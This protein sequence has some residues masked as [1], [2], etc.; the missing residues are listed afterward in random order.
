MLLVPAVVLFGFGTLLVMRSRRVSYL[1]MVIIGMFGFALG[2]TDVAHFLASFLD[3][4]FP[5]SPGAGP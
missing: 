2:S 5:G 3:A 4:L 1:D